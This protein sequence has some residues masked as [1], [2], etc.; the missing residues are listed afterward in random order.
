MLSTTA[1][2]NAVTNR[3]RNA[4]GD[5]ALMT[6]RPG[7]S[8]ASLGG[9]SDECRDRL[10]IDRDEPRVDGFL[11]DGG[12]CRRRR[13]ND[14]GRRCRRDGR[15]CVRRARYQIES[16]LERVVVVAHDEQRVAAQRVL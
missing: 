2:T 5:V 15:Q 8:R 3:W 12:G 1:T 11:R 7:A 4:R 9:T 6:T 10:R 16:M 13:G 14:G